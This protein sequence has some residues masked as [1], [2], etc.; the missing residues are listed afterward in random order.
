MLCA[1]I[2]TVIVIRTAHQR[3]RYLSAPSLMGNEKAGGNSKSE[4]ALLSIQS[5]RFDKEN[6]S[7]PIN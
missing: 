2:V 4:P 5:L 1:P 7:L 6:S 3:L